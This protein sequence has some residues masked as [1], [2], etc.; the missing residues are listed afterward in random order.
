MIGYE[1]GSSPIGIYTT[2][3]TSLVG[4]LQAW[5]KKQHGCQHGNTLI[6]TSSFWLKESSPEVKF[7]GQPQNPHTR[8]VASGE[9]QLEAYLFIYLFMVLSSCPTY[10]PLP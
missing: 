7:L 8:N 6:I 3:K 4:N 9:L 5:M 1:M 10:Q 2:A